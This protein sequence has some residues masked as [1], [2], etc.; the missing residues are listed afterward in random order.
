MIMEK[1]SIVIL[2]YLN[3][4]DTIECVDSIFK[5]EYEFEGIVIVDNNSKNESFKVL[6]NRFKSNKNIIVVKARYNYG[7]AKGNNIGISIA[8]QKFHTDFVFVVNNDTVFL[9]KDYFKKLL[10]CYSNG[11]GMIGSEI[12][13]KGYV[14]QKEI[15]HDISLQGT[16]KEWVDLYLKKFEKEG[17]S[18]LVPKAKRKKKVQILHGCAILFT[19]DFFRYYNG[20]YRRTFLYAEEPILYLMCKKY[21]LRQLYTNGTYIYHKEDQSSELSF[22]NDSKIIQ[23]YRRQS[24]KFLLWWI[25]K[26][27][28]NEIIGQLFGVK[29]REKVY[30]AIL[31]K[32]R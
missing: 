30:E 17:W 24:Y 4:L 22:K 10:A 13:L 3:Y 7:F 15:S 28:V 31:E 26:D 16:F 14:V 29:N 8:R 25:I 2:N 23:D 27:K 32:N 11:V 20:F 5:M 9:E 21:G 12:L 1:I 18:F 6:G 19:P